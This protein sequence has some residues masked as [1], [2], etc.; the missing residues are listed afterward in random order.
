MMKAGLYSESAIEGI[1]VKRT[2]NTPTTSERIV[3]NL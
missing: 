2:Q 1:Q 3:E